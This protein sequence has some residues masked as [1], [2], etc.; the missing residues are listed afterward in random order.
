MSALSF[1]HFL[2][3]PLLFCR[4]RPPS[5]DW[6]REQPPDWFPPQNLINRSRPVTP[7][8]NPFAGGFHAPSVLTALSP[9]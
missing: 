2:A 6:A 7:L 4:T 1:T 8:L 5:S 9:R 3:S